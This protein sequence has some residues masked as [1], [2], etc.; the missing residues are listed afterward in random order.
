MVEAEDKQETIRDFKPLS[1]VIGGTRNNS[2]KVAKSKMFLASFSTYPEHS[3]HGNPFTPSSIMLLTSPTY[4]VAN[5][6]RENEF[7]V[8]LDL[9]ENIFNEACACPEIVNF[10]YFMTICGY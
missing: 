1:C 6:L 4:P 7:I 3:V 10:Y 2:A 9:W 5:R 8:E